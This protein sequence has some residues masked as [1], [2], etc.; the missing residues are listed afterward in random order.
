MIIKTGR[1]KRRRPSRHRRP[2]RTAARTLYHLLDERHAPRAVVYAGVV[3]LLRRRLSA[4]ASLHRP[5]RIG[6][7]I[8]KRLKERARRSESPR[9]VP[10]DDYLTELNEAYNHFFFHYTARRSSSLKRPSSIC[11]GAMTRWTTC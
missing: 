5:H 10:A 7:H 3:E 8:R 11:H 6:V 4:H 9:P 1:R 2:L